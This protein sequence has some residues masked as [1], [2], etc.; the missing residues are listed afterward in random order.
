VWLR[1]HGARARVK[2]TA[3][4]EVAFEQGVACALPFADGIFDAVL[5]V[6]CIFHFPSR[7]AFF[8]EVRRV[9][10]PGGRLVLSD[11]LLPESEPFSATF[12]RALM[13][14]LLSLLFGPLRAV[15][16]SDYKDLAVS[17]GLRPC[18]NRD[19][20]GQSLPTYALLERLLEGKGLQGVIAALLL[21]RMS[22]AQ[23]AG[24]FLYEVLAFEKGLGALA[25]GDDSMSLTLPW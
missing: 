6:E 17:S 13:G 2:P 20:T 3:T 11:F 1:R 24:R 12:E 22:E 9:L 4:N 25:P 7:L 21:R 15:R 16:A 19:I 5:A 10:K 23:R 8:Q 18:L 14:P